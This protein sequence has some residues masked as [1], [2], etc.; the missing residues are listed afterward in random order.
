[1]VGRT[2]LVENFSRESDLGGMS[3]RPILAFGNE[4]SRYLVDHIAVLPAPTS[5][6]QTWNVIK[7]PRASGGTATTHHYYSSDRVTRGTLRRGR[8]GRRLRHHVVA[9]LC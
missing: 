2:H 5:G 4:A 1:M 6:G 9:W 7:C 3:L 8:R